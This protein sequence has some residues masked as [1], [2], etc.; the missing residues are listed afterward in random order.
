MNIE[1]AK[2]DLIQWLLNV[3]D[4]AT[5]KKIKSIKEKQRISI[6]NYNQKI[7]QAEKEIEIGDFYV[8]KDAVNKIQEW[9]EK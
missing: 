1:T 4:E 6:S 5:I 7:N 2:L 8:H 3:R 9:K